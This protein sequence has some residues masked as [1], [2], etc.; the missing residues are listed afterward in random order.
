[1]SL[2]VN[3]NRENVKTKAAGKSEKAEGRQAT[4]KQVAE[5]QVTGRR[6]NGSRALKKHLK[7]IIPQFRLAL[8]REPG[9]APR[10]LTSPDCLEIFMEPLRHYSEEHFIAFHLDAKFNVVGYHEVSH[11]TLSSSLVH[12]REVFKAALLANSYAIIVAHNHPAGSLKPS[13]EDI[14]TTK[15]LIASGK[16]LGI[17]VLDHVIV[18][19][20]GLYSLREENY[21][22]WD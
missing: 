21:D 12:P 13:K 10:A 2:N 9:P 4:G 22:L 5:K 8:I 3:V 6:T 19:A 18:A 15:T 14:E 20:Q 11:G 1:M 7:Y 16:L 17:S